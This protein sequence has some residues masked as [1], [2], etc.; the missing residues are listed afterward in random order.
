MTGDDYDFIRRLLKQRSG[1]MLSAEKQ[2]LVESRLIPLARRSGLTGISDLVTKLKSVGAEPLIVAVL[3]DEEQHPG[4]GRVRL[5]ER[6]G[7]PVDGHRLG[8]AGGFDDGRR[9]HIAAKLAHRRQQIII[10]PHR[11][12]GPHAPGEIE[13]PRVQIHGDGGQRPLEPRELQGQQTDQKLERT[14]HLLLPLH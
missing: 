1:L 6:R 7:V 8:V 10:G 5:G 4:P 2:Y 13:P 9:A 11:G 12:V 14:R 3:C